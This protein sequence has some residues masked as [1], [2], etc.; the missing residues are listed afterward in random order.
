VE[1]TSN[2]IESYFYS[3][4]ERFWRPRL[5]SLH[6]MA[7]HQNE[8]ALV[9]LQISSDMASNSASAQEKASLTSSPQLQTQSSGQNNEK[10]LEEGLVIDE[11]ASR[12]EAIPSSTQSGSEALPSRRWLSSRYRMV[13]CL[14]FWLVMTG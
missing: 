10:G 6:K 7:G 4:F 9:G 14:L 3:Y 13:S 12:A 5:R 1:T 8:N 11:Q 2:F